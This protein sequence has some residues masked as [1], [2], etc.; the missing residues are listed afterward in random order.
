MDIQKTMEFLL[1]YYRITAGQIETLAARQNKAE[2]LVQSLTQQQAALV[3][4]IAQQQEQ[5]GG[6]LTALGTLGDGQR[7][8]AE[9]QLMLT[10]NQRR[11]L[12]QISSM[13]HH[14]E[15][16]AKSFEEWIRRTGF[17]TPSR[18]N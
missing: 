6:L 9:A 4:I 13:A 8:L 12:E 11:T 7:A 1:E 18:P 15:T 10:E 14:V 2:E 3:R 17:Q 16:L 5:I